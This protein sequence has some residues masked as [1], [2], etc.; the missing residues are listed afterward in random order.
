MSKNTQVGEIFNNFASSY[1][2]ASNQYTISRRY[3]IAALFCKGS[4]LD[5]GGASGLFVKYLAPEI[6]PFVLDISFGMCEQARKNQIVK[7]VC[8]DAE[9]LPF[10][11]NSFDSVTSLEMIYYL[12]NPQGFIHE[13]E[14]ILKSDG[15][16]T[17]SFYN[18]KLNFVVR[19]RSFLRRLKL[20]RMFFDDGNPTFTS[21][22]DFHKY[23][24]LTNFEIIKT[25]SVVFFPYKIFHK[26]NLI[27]EK[28]FLKKY[29][30]FNIV[31]LRKN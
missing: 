12:E 13:V 2:E 7:A 5:I 28:T 26:I 22:D 31:A 24:K 14:R 9:K 6:N 11:S 4:M 1:A 15:V 23:I 30:L 20:S 27:L 10:K 16:L 17:L 19:I 25:E 8:A 18:S 29:A 3:K 21:L